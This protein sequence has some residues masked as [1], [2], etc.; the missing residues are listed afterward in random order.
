MITLQ[1]AV[2]LLRIRP[3][4]PLPPLH[5]LHLFLLLTMSLIVPLIPLLM[6]SMTEY[7]EGFAQQ[8]QQCEF[9]LL[10]R[11]HFLLSL[12]VPFRVCSV[13]AILWLSV[14]RFSAD[15]FLCVCVWCVVCCV[16]CLV[17]LPNAQNNTKIRQFTAVPNPLLDFLIVHVACLLL[18]VLLCTLFGFFA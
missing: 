13:C 5:L 3:P 14:G 15:D 4:P 16:L 1:A 12:S 7:R 8:Q 18:F 2:C 17:V 11:F 10:L 9:I 6:M